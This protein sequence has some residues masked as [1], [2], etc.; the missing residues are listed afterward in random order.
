MLWHLSRVSCKVEPC[1]EHRIQSLLC[2][3]ATGCRVIWER[4][5]G[6]PCHAMISEQRGN[7][8]VMIPST[9]QN[10]NTNHWAV[11]SSELFC[12]FI[13]SIPDN[14]LVHQKLNCMTKIVESNLFQQSGKSPPKRQPTEISLLLLPQPTLALFLMSV[15]LLGVCWY[16]RTSWETGFKE[17]GKSVQYFQ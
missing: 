8:S 16:L 14:Q 13:Q 17:K 3:L 4:F 2:F 1:S 9:W 6:R 7:N 10:E 11:S 15:S 12:K 5:A